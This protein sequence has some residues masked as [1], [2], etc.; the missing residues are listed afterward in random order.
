MICT[1]ASLGF[2]GFTPSWRCSTSLR[3]RH[4]SQIHAILNREQPVETLTNGRKA[5]DN[6]IESCQS[7]CRLYI[8]VDSPHFATA[9]RRGKRD[10]AH[11]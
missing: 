11:S 2:V 9:D 5:D 7:E 3:A 10:G 8:V 4:E 1:K 6:M